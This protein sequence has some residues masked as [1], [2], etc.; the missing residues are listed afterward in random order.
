MIGLEK[1]QV[2]SELKVFFS[3][4]GFGVCCVDL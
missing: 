3:K 2:W 4:K 1:A